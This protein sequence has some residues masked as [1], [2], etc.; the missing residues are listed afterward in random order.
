[1]VVR[2]EFRPPQHIFPIAEPEVVGDR[3]R[4]VR[5]NKEFLP[6]RGRAHT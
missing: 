4:R 3:R 6:R 1:M 2:V 5:R